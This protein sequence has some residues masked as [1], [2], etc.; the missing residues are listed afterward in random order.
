MN[1]DLGQLELVFLAYKKA[2]ECFVKKSRDG[3]MKVLSLRVLVLLQVLA[4]LALPQ[5]TAAESQQPFD[6]TSHAHSD[7]NAEEH[8]KDHSIDLQSKPEN[9]STDSFQQSS[10]DTG[11]CHPCCSP[12]FGMCAAVLPKTAAL[13]QIFAGLDVRIGK[14]STLRSFD[15]PP[16]QHPPEYAVS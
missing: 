9:E 4:L 11:S 15:N 13:R 6:G 8:H 3:R 7:L 5:T 12:G 2:L 1:I 10:T 14:T 16:L